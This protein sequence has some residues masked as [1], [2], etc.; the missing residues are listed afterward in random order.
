MDPA[1]GVGLLGAGTVGGT[2]IR[3]LVNDREAIAAKTGLVLDVRRVAVRDLTKQRGF[4][5]PEGVL[6]GDPQAVVEDPSVQLVVELM[7]GR[8]PAGDQDRKSVV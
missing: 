8:E 5:L 6:T 3:R 2:V 7:G 4:D 1:V